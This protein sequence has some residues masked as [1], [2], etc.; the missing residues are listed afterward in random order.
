MTTASS[1]V[2]R[3]SSIVDVVAASRNGLTL[4]EIANAVDLAPSTTHRTVNILLDIGY[5]KVAPENKTYHIGNRLK[6]VLLLTLG[7]DS[8]KDLA[9]PILA[10]LSEQY[11]ETAYV[12]QLTNSGV[13]L[14]D[15][16]LPTK[17]P[18]TLVH[19]G[20]EFPMHATAAGKIVFAYQ[21]QEVINTELSKKIERF[22][23]NTMVRKTQ[24]RSE[25]ERVKSRG[26]AV[27]DVELDPGVYAIAA[28][29]K[30]AGDTVMGAL[31]IAG[32]RDRLLKIHSEEEIAGNLKNCA[33]ELSGF[34]GN[35]NL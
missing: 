12:V 15:F 17:G 8:L 23:P 10:Q 3:I 24:I 18:R 35:E 22:M 9:K 33:R 5:L 2:R 6:R 32:I 13:Q 27:N 25:L 16:Y 34:I 7:S 28:P 30:I 31:A 21:S 19:P 11:R 4:V 29:V 1:P 20:Y 14:V 26:Y